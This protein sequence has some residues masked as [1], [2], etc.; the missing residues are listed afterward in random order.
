M[1]KE[2][3][4]F[5]SRGNVIDL[6]IGIVIGAAFSTVVRSFVDDIL[7]PPIG[8]IS[9]GVDF[10]ELYINLAGTTYPSLAAA[11]AAGAP[12]IR[13]GVFI[14]NILSF[15]IVAVA[16]FFVIKAYNRLR[17]PQLAPATPIGRQCPFCLEPVHAD[18]RRCGHCTSELNAPLAAGRA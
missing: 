11:T 7:M 17:A 5:I 3:R 14:N 1:L 18:A 9:G 2:F 10:A 16:V 4:E 13:Y 15:L 12:L 8:L 6:A